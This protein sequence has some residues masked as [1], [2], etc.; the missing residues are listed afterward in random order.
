MSGPALQPV[1][2]QSTAAII[3]DRLRDAITRGAFPPGAQLGEV[4][5][6]G[7]LGVS[8]GPLREAMQRLVQEGLLR[9]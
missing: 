2:R 6:A 8:R 3:A 5:L 9:G 7:R 4:E 1:S